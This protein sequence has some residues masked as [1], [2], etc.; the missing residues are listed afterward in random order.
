MLEDAFAAQDLDENVYDKSAF[1]SHPILQHFENL[2][3]SSIKSC[4]YLFNY[5]YFYYII[6][7]YYN[8]NFFEYKRQE[9]GKN[10]DV[11]L[12]EFGV[13]LLWKLH[14][15]RHGEKKAAAE[16]PKNIKIL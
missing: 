9:L 1:Y 14:V 15:F 2:A 4:M 13:E 16:Y 12:F 6:Y 5:Y 11:E 8:C 7:Y 3:K 10:F